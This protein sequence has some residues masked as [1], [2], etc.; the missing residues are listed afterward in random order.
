MWNATGKIPEIADTDLIEKVSPVGV[1]S[2]DAGGPVQHVGPFGLLVP[3]Q[4]AHAACVQSHLDAGDRFRNTKLPLCHLAGPAAVRLSH[5]RVSKRET[6]VWRRAG[7][8]GGRSQPRPGV[9]VPRS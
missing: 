2:R 9:K 7:I 4:F 6:E 5:M 8:R 1:D 3:M